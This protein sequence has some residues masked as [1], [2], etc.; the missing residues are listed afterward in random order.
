MPTKQTKKSSFSYIENVV[1]SLET[2]NFGPRVSAAARLTSM[3]VVV[4]CFCILLPWGLNKAT[5]YGLGLAFVWGVC[6][7]LAF[8]KFS[9]Q[10][11]SWEQ[12]LDAA[13][14]VYEP[15]D[16]DAYLQLQ[17]VVA[18]DGWAPAAINS[19]VAAEKAAIYA[20]EIREN[21]KGQ[22]KFLDRRLP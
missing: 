20:E 16:K 21:S 1:R 5:L 19:W 15:I 7:F 4:A 3:L 17:K 13:L 11:D 8:L 6:F 22:S 9:K 2:S 18:L 10:P 14:A 12:A